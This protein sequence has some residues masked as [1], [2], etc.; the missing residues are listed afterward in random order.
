MLYSTTKSIH[1]FVFDSDDFA[2]ISLPL[3][4][5][6]KMNAIG[7]DINSEFVYWVDMKTN[8]IQRAYEDG[9]GYSVV[10][11]EDGVTPFDLAIDPY[12]EQIYWTDSSRNDINVFSLKK[13]KPLGVVTSRKDERPRF[14]VLYPE[15]G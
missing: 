3:H 6:E 2:D 4:E 12:G 15:K 9:S 10:I 1:R 7:Y 8:S 11:S 14:I 5:I 13:M